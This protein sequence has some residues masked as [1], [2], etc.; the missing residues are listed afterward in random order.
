VI[1]ELWATLAVHLADKVGSALDPL[2]YGNWNATLCHGS[3]LFAM[4]LHAKSFDFLHGSLKLGLKYVGHLNHRPPALG[5][6]LVYFVGPKE[7]LSR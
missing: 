6:I 7:G 3:L 5:T 2:L 1:V 4:V